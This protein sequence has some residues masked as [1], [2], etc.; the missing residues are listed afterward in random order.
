MTRGTINLISE[1]ASNFW[2]ESGIL[3]TYPLQPTLLEQAICLLFPINTVRLNKLTAHKVASWL[4]ARNHTI[5]VKDDCR[6]CGLLFVHHGQGIVF[7]DG[8]LP[9]NEQCYTLAH[10]IGHYLIEFEHPQKQAKQFIGDSIS[11]VFDGARKPTIE[12]HLT[13]IITQ[14][15]VS[16]YIHLLEREQSSA[17]ERFQIWAA[18]NRAD[19][20]A[21]ELIAP[22]DAI[23]GELRAA[24]KSWSFTR[25]Q[26]DLPDVLLRNFG[27]PRSVISQYASAIAY[28]L[29]PHGDGL[30]EYIS[31]L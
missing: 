9:I 7:I 25:I 8:T 3:P 19:E 26:E 31:R 17:E 24:G 27:L 23:C 11:E 28:R 4:A 2:K 16:P 10:E 14:T 6:L 30:I 1:L 21:F 18:E 5:E 29:F 20:L 15:S 12:E 22:F 13:G